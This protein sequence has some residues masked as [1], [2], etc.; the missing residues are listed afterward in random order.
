MFLKR[1]LNSKNHLQNPFQ[2]IKNSNIYRLS[3]ELNFKFISIAYK[4]FHLNNAT[5]KVNTKKFSENLSQKKT[6]QSIPVTNENLQELDEQI[7]NANNNLISSLDEE[8]KNPNNNQI[9][10]K[11]DNIKDH[12]NKFFK[13]L[14]EAY[15]QDKSYH[16]LYENKF[17]LFL[18]KMQKLMENE[19]KRRE[20]NE[21]F[22]KDIR[23]LSLNSKEPLRDVLIHYQCFR[24]ENGFEAEAVSEAILILGKI[25]SSRS[26]FHKCYTDMTHWEFINSTRL[27][28]L[29]D[30]IKFAIVNSVGYINGEQI[31]KIIE[32]LKLC[33]YKNTEL[34]LL[35]EEK[36]SSIINEKIPFL[37]EK[38]ERYSDIPGT[39][40]K[41]FMN[42]NPYA[43]DILE[44]SN[45]KDYFEKL[46][47]LK[48]DDNEDSEKAK[49]KGSL[50]EEKEKIKPSIN[51]PNEN[52]A[53]EELKNLENNIKNIVDLMQETKDL[54]FNFT[55]NLNNLIDQYFK[56]EQLM[57]DNHEIRENP[58][59]KY[60][61]NII[62]D[63]FIGMGFIDLDTYNSISTRKLS[64]EEFDQIKT[65]TVIKILR[66]YIYVN[67][68]DLFSGI[69]DEIESTQIKVKQE[70]KLNLIK[71]K[72]SPATLSECMKELSEYAKITNIDINSEDYDKLEFNLDYYA[73]DIPEKPVEFIKTKP[74]FTK[75]YN[76]TLKFFKSVKRDLSKKY[77]N[78]EDFKFHSNLILSYANMNILN[79]DIFEN[80]S[81]IVY[82]ILT[83][84]K[85]KFSNE[86]LSNL[87]YGCAI[88]GFDVNYN[89]WNLILKKIN[90]EIIDLNF[91][92]AVKLI[93][94]LLAL[95]IKIDDKIIDL[96]RY[97]NSFDIYNHLTE[98]FKFYNTEDLFYEITIALRENTRKHKLDFKDI[99]NLIYLSNK[100]FDNK[101]VLL[102]RNEL[103]LQDPLKDNIKKLFIEKFYKNKL[104]DINPSDIIKSKENSLGFDKLIVPFSPDFVL[105]IYGNKICLF[106]NS[107][108]KNFKNTFL[109]GHQRLLRNIL[110]KFY[111]CVCVF[112][113]ITKF[114]KFNPSDFTIEVNETSGFDNFDKFIFSSILHKKPKL[115]ESIKILQKLNN[116]F[117]KFISN[118]LDAN[119][120][121][122]DIIQSTENKEN[123]E[124]FLK[125]LLYVTELENKIIYDCTFAQFDLN[126]LEIRKVFSVLSIISDTLS[127]GFKRLI[128]KNIKIEE[129]KYSS[130]KEF[131]KTILLEYEKYHE[132]L[133][134]LNKQ[135]E[136]ILLNDD[137]W[138]GK[139]LNVDLINSEYLTNNSLENL[140]NKNISVEILNN[141][142]M[143]YGEYNP[144]SDWEEELR[145]N[146]DNFN[147]FTQKSNNKYY[148][149]SH[150]LGSR[151]VAQGIFPHPR[152]FRVMKQHL[153]TTEKN[154]QAEHK[155]N[156]ENSYENELN[157][158]HHLNEIL[159][160]EE[161]KKNNHLQKEIFPTQLSM[162]IN[163][164]NI[165]N[166]LKQN[167]T[168]NQILRYI[169]EFEFTE[170]LIEEHLNVHITETK[171]TANIEYVSRNAESFR[172]FHKKLDNLKEQFDE[173]DKYIM[174]EYYKDKDLLSYDKKATPE[175]IKAQLEK[176]MQKKIE[177]NNDNDAL[178]IYN[179]N[180]I[181]YKFNVD[182]ILNSLSI[183]MKDSLTS[184]SGFGASVH[185]EILNNPEKY[186]DLKRRISERNLILFKIVIKMIQNKQI[187][188]NEKKYL[189]H[190]YKQIQD[191]NILNLES[192]TINDHSTKLQLK[193][194][195]SN[196][197]YA[198]NTLAN[199]DIKED[200]YHF[201]LSDLILE[202][203][204]FLDVNTFNKIIYEL[205]SEFKS[206]DFKL[207]TEKA[208]LF[209]VNNKEPALLN[210]EIKET[211]WRVSGFF[212]ELD[213]EKL[214]NFLKVKRGKST[215]DKF[216][217][218]LDEASLEEFIKEVNKQENRID[219]LEKWI[220]RKEYEFENR[221]QLPPDN[222]KLNDTQINKIIN[223]KDKMYRTKLLS[224]MFKTHD[225]K[226][227]STRDV[228]K[229]INQ[230]IEF[231]PLFNFKYPQSI[232][233]IFASLEDLEEHSNIYKEDLQMLK[234]YKT[235]FKIEDENPTEFLA[236]APIKMDQEKLL[237]FSTK[238]SI[239][240]QDQLI[241]R[242]KT[243]TIPFVKNV[244]QILLSN[245]SKN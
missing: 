182:S 168:D 202:L 117:N 204:N 160:A 100:Y 25:Y 58:Y 234:T 123:L 105:D 184:F 165:N 170:K 155:I 152:R 31:R 82:N 76:S 78:L 151:K 15:S 73:K 154:L 53:D 12:D 194:L 172:D 136:K 56:I 233:D 112:I 201:S 223:K 122:F 211:I 137:N 120:P 90:F 20:R 88:S 141:N 87:I 14:L 19:N 214:K 203:N 99:N 224:N 64:S 71:N 129:G 240:N 98:D 207:N 107:L 242:V 57:I 187:S 30:D 60:S 134:E 27:Y 2:I 52:K 91:D 167:F 63:K 17:D 103:D 145:A 23:L 197:L 199:V 193:D 222:L 205:F 68:P 148:F 215:F 46:M 59:T 208:S 206:K 72:I 239:I 245:F 37:E 135:S 237:N 67:F 39:G 116:Q 9:S 146:L 192:N 121:E 209:D 92:S 210:Q 97:L 124:I 164:L 54:Q 133:K 230:F 174:K 118:L 232:K 34:A 181:N 149:N 33:N 213:V 179:P 41:D 188:E 29:I 66:D 125:N 228:N 86:E 157:R 16:E 80:S 8:I 126:L 238:D 147:Y 161:I 5:C 101:A 144:Y 198:L 217:L 50:K 195:S 70:M 79:K 156:S 166:S 131:L 196:D 24:N 85:C 38:Y 178:S 1:I 142:F 49:N 153:Y 231:L 21:I 176:K 140:K 22:A 190:L 162:K 113:P 96:V 11:A 6:F 191:S 130:F 45:I 75:L 173:Y 143:W 175:N 18:I 77:R 95:E 235:L 219:Y 35:I 36:L 158:Y 111:G 243:S 83:N 180:E 163:L 138:V 216:W 241:E 119:N 89:F 109:N 108:D 26:R 48:F 127:E 84:E 212:D 65:E 132:L 244:S 226:V 236:V 7:N 61:L 183:K 47:K 4:N 62:Q 115:Y 106:L 104:G 189:H 218:S 225:L 229:F 110:E 44:D 150:E 81:R 171:S 185:N 69:I 32:G 13:D 43:N 10:S 169:S 114:I 227:V 200:L 40:K 221:I 159:I 74:E 139:R 51:T 93:W 102:K 55:D 186:L 42:V 177:E 220:K 128:V 3:N 94:S 28:H